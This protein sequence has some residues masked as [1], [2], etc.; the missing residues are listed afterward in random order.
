VTFY[1]RDGKKKRDVANKKK[2]EGQKKRQK[3]KDHNPNLLSKK[4]KRMRKEGG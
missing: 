4:Q 3:V 2:R 1:C